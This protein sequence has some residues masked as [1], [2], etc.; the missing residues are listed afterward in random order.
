MREALI[1]LLK[2]P[3][4]ENY[5]RLF[6]MVTSGDA[7][8]PYSDEM[9]RVHS[10]LELGD[11]NSAYMVLMQSWSNLMLSPRAHL[12]AGI[13]LEQLGQP[14][15]CRAE[16]MIAS[17]ILE[18]I[19]ASGDGS[20]ENPYLVTRTSDEYD[21][22]SYLEKTMRQQALHEDEGRYFD[23]LELEDGGSLWFD[24]TAPYTKLSEAF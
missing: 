13:C 22:L 11:A 14:D 5:M 8:D 1:E 23:V 12:A 16:K 17:A 7:Y 21:L 20:R 9:R 10:H 24:I 6:E 2:Q 3:N 15:G 4:R 18:G 19:L